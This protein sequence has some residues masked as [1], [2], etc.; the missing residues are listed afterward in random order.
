MPWQQKVFTKLLGLQFSIRY[1]KGTTNRAADALSRR[2]ALE[3]SLCAISQLHPAW[4]ADVVA[5]Y[6]SDPQA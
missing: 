4:L 6:D 2:P 3:A 5:A 1:K